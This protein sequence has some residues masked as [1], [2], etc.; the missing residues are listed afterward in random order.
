MVAVN[1]LPHLQRKK[2]NIKLV[3]LCLDKYM[4]KF[5][6]DRILNRLLT[7]MRD[8]ETKEISVLVNNESKTFVVHLIDSLGDNLGSHQIG[9]YVENFSKS[10]YFCRYCE[11]SRIKFHKNVFRERCMRTVDPY[12]ECLQQFGTKNTSVKAIKMDSPLNKLHYFHVAGPGLPPCLDNDIF[13]VFVK[14]GML[15]AIKYL[16]GKQCFKIGFPNYCL[17]NITILFETQS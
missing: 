16:V 5:G 1:L 13:E 11:I 10:H 17:N 15:L 8:L 9:G 7:D 4:N 2:E 3:L 6:W 14:K 12:N